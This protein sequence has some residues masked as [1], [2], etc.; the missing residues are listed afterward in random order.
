VLYRVITEPTK[1]GTLGTVGVHRHSWSAGLPND[2]TRERIIAPYDS[3]QVPESIRSDRLVGE[4][5]EADLIL[6]QPVPGL[7]LDDPLAA[8]RGCHPAGASRGRA[9]RRGAVRGR[10]PANDEPD[11]DE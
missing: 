2:P 10:E 4:P 9:A 5:V 3:P 1:E 11:E 7:T 8:D 6:R